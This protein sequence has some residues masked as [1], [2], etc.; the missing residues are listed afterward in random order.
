M[1]IKITNHELYP[2]YFTSKTRGIVVEVSKKEYSAITQEQ[3]EFKAF[4]AR[5]EALA[6]HAINELAMLRRLKH[7]RAQH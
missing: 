2:Y 7:N 4:Q 1:K 3:L 6:E 5:L